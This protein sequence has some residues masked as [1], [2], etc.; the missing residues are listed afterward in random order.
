MRSVLWA[1]GITFLLL[2]V[3][4]NTLLWAD[5]GH[6][7]ALTQDE[8]GS[9]TFPTSC[10]HEVAADFNRAV[11]LLHSF[12]Y[13]Q[14]RKGFEAVAR[15]D[16]HCAMAEWG[17]A[18]SHYHGLWKNGDLDTGRAAF[19]GLSKLRLSIKAQQ[20]ARWA[21]SRRLAKSTSRTAATKPHNRP[22]TSAG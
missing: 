3:L 21:T 1:S 16:P 7:H 2:G 19:Q 8:I 14:S 4:L 13:E 6:H 22:H 15:K 12:Q 9:V 5:E 20:L 10:S 18:M 11:A 17:I